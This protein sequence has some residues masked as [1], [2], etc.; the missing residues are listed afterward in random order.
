M[1]LSPQEVGELVLISVRAETAT[2]VVARSKR[3]LAVGARVVYVPR[4][5]HKTP[6]GATTVHPEKSQRRQVLTEKAP[7]VA[8]SKRPAG[9]GALQE[10]YTVVRGDTLWS[11]AARPAIYR[12]PFMWPIIY[13][14]NQA[15]I[16]DPDLI[17]P[18][19][20]FVIPRTYASEEAI[21]A[22]RRARS[23][24]PW[25]LGDGPDRYILEGV[26]Q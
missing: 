9:A 14:A 4:P 23:R 12:D 21:T 24:G 26:R 8:T 7:T 1:R 22:I 5:R 17:F 15:Q 6:V 19:Q 18:Q 2:A 3:E 11:I 25:R 13:K 16:V 10:Q 20:R